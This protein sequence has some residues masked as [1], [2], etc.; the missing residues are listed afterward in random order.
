MAPTLQN[1]NPQ[2]ASTSLLDHTASFGCSQQWGLTEYLQNDN[3]HEEII[4]H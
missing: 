1:T 3:L 4:G 2:I